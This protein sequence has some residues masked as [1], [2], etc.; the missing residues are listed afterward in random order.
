MESKIFKKLT[1]ETLPKFDIII[2]CIGCS[3][4]LDACLYYWSNMK[5]SNYEIHVVT[6]IK[7]IKTIDVCSKYLNVNVV[8]YNNKN[9]C[10][11]KGKMIEYG[12][13]SIKNI[14]EYLFLSDADIIFSPSTLMRVANSF[15]ENNKI[16]SSYREDISEYHV[17][18]FFSNYR[19]EDINWVWEN[20]SLETISPAPFMGWFLV[21]PSHYIDRIDFIV[22]HRGYDEIDWRVFYQLQ[23][24]GLKPEKIHIDNVPLHIYH[25]KKGEQWR[26][27]NLQCFE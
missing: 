1:A 22:N 7:D 23:K 24:L 25:G 3:E 6:Y 15:T 20:L 10:H 18:L 5:Y 12:I 8:I 21:F 2:V 27:I 4:R 16:I 17:P 19:N 13:S 9:D 14:G 11:N 26:G